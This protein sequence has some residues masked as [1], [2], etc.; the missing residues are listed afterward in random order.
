M[1]EGI[2]ARITCVHAQGGTMNAGLMG[3]I[4]GGSVARVMGG[5]VAEDQQRFIAFVHGG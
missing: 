3:K 4:F 1:P 5:P 2:R